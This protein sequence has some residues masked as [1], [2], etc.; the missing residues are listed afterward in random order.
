MKIIAIT[1]HPASGKDTVADYLVS[2]GFNKITMSDILREEMTKLG[3]VTD[4]SHIHQFAKEMRQKHG[5]GYLSEEIIKRLKGD[6][7]ISGVRNSKELA[8]FKEKLGSDFKL[9]VVEALLE[10]RY[11]W[12]KER[13][14][15]GDEVS[16]E[17]FK[18]EKDQEKAS[19]SGSHEVDLVISQFQDY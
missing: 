19:N 2:K 14:R 10:V 17:V 6:T 9:I 13:R 3:I 5:N 4:R 8:I 18:R 16:L 11:K 1:G 7:V 15:I 12:A